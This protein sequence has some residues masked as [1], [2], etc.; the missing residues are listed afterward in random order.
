MLLVAEL[1]RVRG[2][3]PLHDESM[4]CEELEGHG[5]VVVLSKEV[6]QMLDYE[7]ASTKEF[8]TASAKQLTTNLDK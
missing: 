4:V 3:R 6:S 5:I 1:R 7:T 2:S 8:C